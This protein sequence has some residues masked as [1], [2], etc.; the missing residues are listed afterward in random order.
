MSEPLD[1]NGQSIKPNF[2][3]SNNR[4]KA[5]LGLLGLCEG[6]TSDK[7]IN[8]DEVVFLD[9]WLKDNHEFLKGDSDYRDI[10]DAAGDVLE[11][12][13][14][15]ADEHA[16]LMALLRT[17]VQIRGEEAYVCE[18][19]EMEFLLGFLRRIADDQNVNDFEILSLKGWLQNTLLP[20]DRWPNSILVERIAQI[21]DDLVID[22]EEADDLLRILNALTG[23]SLSQGLTSGT[24]STLPLND[25]CSLEFEDKSFCITGKCASGPRK[26]VEAEIIDRGGTPQSSVTRKLDCLV[27]GTLS[28]RDRA[29][30]TY[31]TKIEKP[32][33][34]GAMAASCSLFLKK[35]FIRVFEPHALETIPA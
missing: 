7:K 27:T 30:T 33:L 12:G 32:W 28:S 23:D 17:I 9:T 20:L 2:R 16:D 13:I 31:A 11:D 10:T 24:S 21:I 22:A 1:N 25:I 6:L 19:S 8:V 18:R 14:I 15:M 29:Q 5:F 4:R 26:R 3:L 35:P 34:S